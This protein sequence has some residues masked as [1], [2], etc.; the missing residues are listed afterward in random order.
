MLEY[1]SIIATR[2]G[3]DGEGE[4]RRY[5]TINSLQ[6]RHRFHLIDIVLATCF[7]KLDL[8]DDKGFVL[9]CPGTSE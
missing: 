3:D 2:R 6:V 5:Y 1:N 4:D 9:N 8:N 7:F